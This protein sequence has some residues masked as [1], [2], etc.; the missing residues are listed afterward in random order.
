MPR[1]HKQN[2]YTEKQER[3]IYILLNPISK[4]FYIDYTLT[5]NLRKMYT[6]HYIETRS[7]TREMVRHMKH[8]LSRP[9]CFELNRLYCTKVEAYR[10]VIAWTKIFVEQGYQNIDRGNVSEY[11]N[12]IF[13][14][15]KQIYENYKQIVLSEEFACSKCQFPVYKRKIC[16]QKVGDRDASN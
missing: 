11:I 4:V 16:E 14:E 10:H 8:N 15:T 1:P 3:S 6:E 9:C 13:G 7:K 2:Q 12:D 5:P